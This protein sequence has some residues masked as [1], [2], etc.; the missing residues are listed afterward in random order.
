MYK[1]KH[2]VSVHMAEQKRW[3]FN[4]RNE[5]YGKRRN[6]IYLVYNHVNYKPFC[7]RDIYLKF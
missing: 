5:T 1:M 7:N 2:L 3:F 4:S 6:I